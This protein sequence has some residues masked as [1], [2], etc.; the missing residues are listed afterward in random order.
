MA[1]KSW[2]HNLFHHGMGMM[3]VLYT[4]QN[5]HVWRLTRMP[6]RRGGW[7][8]KDPQDNTTLWQGE[9]LTEASGYDTSG[10]VR[11]RSMHM[12]MQMHGMYDLSTT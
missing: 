10:W 9:Q 8:H 1:R 12:H 2:E 11:A 5:T 3:G 6:E 7:V 4:H